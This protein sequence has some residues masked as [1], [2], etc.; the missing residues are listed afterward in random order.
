ME[1]NTFEVLPTEKKRYQK[2]AKPNP[3]FSAPKTLQI[4][5]LTAAG[6]S[7]KEIAKI[8]DFN[9]STVKKIQQDYKKAFKHL[10]KAKTF[11]EVRSDLLASAQLSALETAVDPKRLAKSS[12]ISAAKVFDI[13]HKA[14][15]LENNQSTENLAH[16]HQHIGALP[17][18]EK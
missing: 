7:Q 1:P 14:E 18:D 12:S 5:E 16:V 6:L 10:D 13:F 15:R 3:G 2:R 8:A 17:L 9:V 4:L 11:R